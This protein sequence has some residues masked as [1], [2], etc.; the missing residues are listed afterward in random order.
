MAITTNWKSLS[1][2]NHI[3]LLQQILKQ[4]IIGKK[5][6]TLRM[7]L[8]GL[9]ECLGINDSDNQTHDITIPI[10]LK[11]CGLEM[12]VVIQSEA[13]KSVDPNTLNAIK[14]GMT[15]ALTWNEQLLNG[16]VVSIQ[17]IANK[18][19]LDRSYVLR[20]LRLAYLAPDIILSIFDGAIPPDLTMNKLRK[21][22][23]LDWE[24]QRKHLG[25]TEILPPNVTRKIPN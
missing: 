2:T 10:Q 22:F 9:G 6:I 8:V 14:K 21:G 24:Q 11:R 23:P 1:V 13:E 17:E 19:Q 20:R 4:V 7:N 18:E 3:E 12:K 16:D 5:Q 25:F 15:E